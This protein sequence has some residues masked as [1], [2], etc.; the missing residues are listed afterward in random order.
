MREPASTAITAIAS[1]RE[2]AALFQ[3]NVLVASEIRT[4][5]DRWLLDDLDRG[6]SDV[7]WIAAEPSAAM[8]EI[9]A[10]FERALRVL[11]GPPPSIEEAAIIAV[12][13]Y[14]EAIADGCVPPYEGMAAIDK[15]LDKQFLDAERAL[16]GNPEI[17]SRDAEQYV[18]HALGLQS[19]YIWYREL[20]DADDGS[21]L[22]YYNELP[23]EQQLSKFQEELQMA[24]RRL[25]DRLRAGT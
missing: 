20:Q 25:A 14:V 9:R 10:P 6:S 18:G 12:R 2:A 13:L 15:D 22:L 7:A 8:D 5:C 16:I 3:L 11:S 1:P 21:M 19:L 24:A 23:R 4:L 17:S